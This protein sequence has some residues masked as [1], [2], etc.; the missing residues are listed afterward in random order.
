PAVTLIDRHTAF[1]G[2]YVIGGNFTATLD[3]GTIPTG[4]NPGPT[5]AALGQTGLIPADA[6]SLRFTANLDVSS[7]FVTFNGQNLPFI[8]LTS[9]SN[10]EVYAADIS[11]FAGQ[12][13]E[14]LFTER[15]N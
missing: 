5:S 1:Y 2:N 8:P 6:R 7:L 11:R 12:T 9:G 14:L 13:G 4:V 10:F 15:P 3:S